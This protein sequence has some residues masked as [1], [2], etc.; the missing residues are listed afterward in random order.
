MTTLADQDLVSV[1]SLTVSGNRKLCS[2]H[3]LNEVLHFNRG[4]IRRGR[5]ISGND[6][7]RVRFSIL[8]KRDLILNRTAWVADFLRIEH[9]HAE[10]W[11][12]EK[13]A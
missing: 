7:G 8:Y 11:E 6:N 1:R 4:K 13:E 5:R 2:G 10:G 3:L 12:G 9:L